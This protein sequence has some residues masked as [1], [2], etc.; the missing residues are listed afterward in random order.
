MK[1]IFDVE[2]L[3]MEDFEEALETFGE[4]KFMAINL[5]T[6]AEVIEEHGE[7]MLEQAEEA[8]EKA[9]ELLEEEVEEA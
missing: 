4:D 9:K 6:T 3:D 7:D 8:K 5:L 2:G 1:E